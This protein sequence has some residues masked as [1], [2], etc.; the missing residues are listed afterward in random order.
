MPNLVAQCRYDGTMARRRVGCV[1]RGRQGPRQRLP[2]HPLQYLTLPFDHE[3]GTCVDAEGI[4]GIQS[5]QS[6]SGTA[7]CPLTCVTGAGVP[8]CGGKG[9]GKLPGGRDDCCIKFV[10]AGD[11]CAVSGKAPCFIPPR[12]CL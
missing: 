2:F 8:Q 10:L 9:C 6:M 12:E 7:C 5:V 11:D 1:F 3:A 4:P